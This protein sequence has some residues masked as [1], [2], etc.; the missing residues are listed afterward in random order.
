[1]PLESREKDKKSWRGHGFNITSNTEHNALFKIYIIICNTYL[2][3]G[4]ENAKHKRHIK[5]RQ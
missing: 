2:V 1:M 4:P 5:Q 3:C